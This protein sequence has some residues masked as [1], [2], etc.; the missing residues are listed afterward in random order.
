MSDA[1]K[2]SSA[3]IAYDPDAGFAAFIASGYE[4]SLPCPCCGEDWQ[5][6]GSTKDVHQFR[7]R[8]HPASGQREYRNVP[9][10]AAI[11][12]AEGRG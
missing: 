7:H 4:P 3:T 1:Q 12:A 2:P 10:I 9:V 6:M 11:N 5:Y 8:H